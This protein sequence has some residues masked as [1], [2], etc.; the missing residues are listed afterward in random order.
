MIG[1]TPRI[2]GITK[3]KVLG[4]TR[5]LV[6]CARI[7]EKMHNNILCAGAHA[8]THHAYIMYMYTYLCAYVY[9]AIIYSAAFAKTA[10]Y[11]HV[12]LAEGCTNGVAG[13]AYIIPPPLPFHRPLVPTCPLCQRGYIS[14]LR[15]RHRRII[16]IHIYIYTDTRSHFSRDKYT[17]IH[18]R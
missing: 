1:G 4:I 7:K 12:D 15:R 6:Q 5:A 9:T 11:L 10:L 18:T 17:R 13:R 3:R 2:L 16:I 14:L 8:R